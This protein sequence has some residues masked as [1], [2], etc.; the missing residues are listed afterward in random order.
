[1]IASLT[2]AVKSV[3]PLFFWILLGFGAKRILK[4]PDSA[5]RFANKLVFVFLLPLSIVLNI[6][7]T[8]IRHVVQPGLI[9]FCIVAIL[10]TWGGSWIIATR[11]EPAHPKRGAMIQGM[12]RSNFVLFG[13]PLVS[14]IYSGAHAGVTSFMIA[15]VVPLYNVL[16]VFTL[17]T[18][19]RDR[20]PG[21][22]RIG[23]VLL[24][25]LKNPLILGSMVG[26]ALLLFGVKLP[27][28]LVAG[29]NWVSRASTY[30]ALTA[31]GAA[32]KLS[33][34]RGDLKRLFVVVPMRLIIWP[35]IMLTCAIL[36][37][38][39]G[40][41][42][43]TLLAAF[44]APSAVNSYTM[45]ELMGNDGPLAASIVVFTT[46]FAAITVFLFVFTLGGLGFIGT[47]T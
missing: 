3:L 19:R 38:F 47:V 34:V 12:F 20:A 26:L 30:F 29:A 5:V 15:I 22:I 23:K 2:L 44:A 31:M 9:C 14:N 10:A 37:G 8:H 17:E 46:L 7:Q 36:V 28:G 11:R 39:R 21:K 35:L 13:M 24:G 25:V 43:T 45:A 33:S 1:M 16:A 40:V 27:D 42:L 4:I 6:M 32:F 41:E 18:H